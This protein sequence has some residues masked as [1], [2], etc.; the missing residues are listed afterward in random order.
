MATTIESAA[1]GEGQL[2][3][4]VSRGARPV[5]PTSLLL[6]S[7][8]VSISFGAMFGL[9]A[10][11]QRS[12]K[13]SSL[14]LGVITSCAFAAGF[15]VQMG[16]AR[17]ADRGYGRV[18]LRAGIGL[19]IGSCV[20]IAAAH[21]LL[22]L[23]LGRIAL[24]IGEGLFLPAARRVVIVRNPD[25]VGAALGRL[26]AAQTAGF[27]LG[28]PFAAY[29]AASTALWVPFAVI[30]VALAL[31][32]P[33]VFRFDVP[34]AANLQRSPV[35]RR[36]IAIPGVRIGIWI[37]VGLTVS[38]GVYDSL[39]AK[40]LKDLGASTKFVGVSLTLFGLPIVLFSGFAG[41][42]A[43]R[44]GP[45]R[46]GAVALGASMPFIFGYGVLKSYVL[47][48]VFAFG[49]SSFDA[50]VVPASQSQVA[51]SVDDDLVAAG[52]G[53]L[54][55]IGLL[56]AAISA[57]IAAPIYDHFGARVLWSALSVA[58]GICGLGAYRAHRRLTKPE[59]RSRLSVPLDIAAGDQAAGFVGRFEKRI[60]DHDATIASDHGNETW[61]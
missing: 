7:A 47:I 38:I 24:G 56:A 29:V 13:F 51:R 22:P 39:W 15:V 49:H 14:W 37:G 26:G 20:L 10:D 59:T 12:L 16:L 40:F 8:A 1:G 19:C 27:L 60:A 41:R 42:L 52:Q 50:V 57:L 36:L 23:L 55:G 28:P 32:T 46:I 44:I 5:L 48:A 31:V 54:E 58:V 43:D 2:D 18:M 25:A 17:F 3:A 11:L 35:L 4:S 9:L 33:F 30:A 53:L 61:R 45:A 34:A 21:S 6:A